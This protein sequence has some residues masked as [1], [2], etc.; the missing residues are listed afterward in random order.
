MKNLL[1][2]LQSNFVF[3]LLHCLKFSWELHV[4]NWYKSIWAMA[5]EL[6]S[7]QISI[8]ISFPGKLVYIY[9]EWDPQHDT[10]FNFK[11]QQ[12]FLY[13]STLHPQKEKRRGE[14]ER[15]NS[16]ILLLERLEGQIWL[17]W[18]KFEVKAQHYPCI[19]SLAFVGRVWI[20]FLLLKWKS[21][22]ISCWRCY[23]V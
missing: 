12:I 19:I 5:H 6:Y 15:E 2:K 10:S 14:R 3:F 17:I 7:T 20:I 8:K 1:N 9:E 13:G 21:D 16:L 18:T 4:A 23:L 22:N 11:S